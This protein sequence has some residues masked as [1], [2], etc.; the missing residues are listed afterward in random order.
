MLSNGA[1]LELMRERVSAAD[2]ML[3]IT[4]SIQ[5]M[6]S[7][8][9]INVD[10]HE[11]P[12]DDEEECEGILELCHGAAR[13]DGERL[14]L[15]AGN[16][17]DP[18]GHGSLRFPCSEAEKDIIFAF[19]KKSFGKKDEDADDEEDTDTVVSEDTEADSDDE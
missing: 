15:I 2:T 12:V 1:R 11:D 6:E 14:E 7:C 19:I 9:C 18:N 8:I 4:L 5:G 17:E 3:F 16:E 13:Y 10:Q